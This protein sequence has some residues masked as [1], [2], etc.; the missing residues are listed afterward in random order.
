MS[1]ELEDLRRRVEQ[2]EEHTHLLERR[3][4]CDDMRHEIL[5]AVR[6]PASID[7]GR[8]K[9][10]GDLAS[11]E[12]GDSGQDLKVGRLEAMTRSMLLNQGDHAADLRK[13]LSYLKML[14]ERKA[15]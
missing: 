2:L 8:G 1:T 9:T 11:Q 3:L 7:G 6:V 13:A 14:V 10:S 4:N 5:Y 15:S 12:E